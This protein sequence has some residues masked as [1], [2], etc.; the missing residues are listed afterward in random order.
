M[1]RWEIERR[2]IVAA[3]PTLYAE[4]LWRVYVLGV[5]IWAIIA[6]VFFWIIT[7]HAP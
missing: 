1:S 5:F 7:G 2:R 6:G 3:K 4:Q